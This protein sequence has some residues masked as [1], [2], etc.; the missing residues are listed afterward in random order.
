MTARIDHAAEALR[1]I[2]MAGE[3]FVAEEGWTETTALMA[4]LDAQTHATLALVEQQRTAN[5]IALLDSYR[6]YDG[7]VPWTTV[8]DSPAYEAMRQQ[9]AAALGIEVAS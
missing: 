7:S 2:D 6:D 8:H 4:T 3:S 1:L 9:V 5:L